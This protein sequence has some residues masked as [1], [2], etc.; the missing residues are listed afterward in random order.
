MKTPRFRAWEFL[1]PGLDAADMEAGLAFSPTGGIAMVSERASI[2]Q[3]ILL[4]LS[5]R[6]GERVMRP[7]YGC[8]LFRLVFQPNDATTAGLAIHY[9]RQALLRWEPRIEIVSLRALEDPGDPGRLEITLD[10]RR[11]STRDLD[12]LTYAVQLTGEAL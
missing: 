11:K 4:L 6:P 2:R 3:A 12:Q 5:T 8:D 7:T 1:Y 10:Y 9:V